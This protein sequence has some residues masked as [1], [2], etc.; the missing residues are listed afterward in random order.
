M[1]IIRIPPR[2]GM[3]YLY[4]LALLQEAHDDEL[5]RTWMIDHPCA[6]TLT[7]DGPYPHAC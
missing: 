3:S 1:I 5:L 7:G 2:L 4:A 6:G